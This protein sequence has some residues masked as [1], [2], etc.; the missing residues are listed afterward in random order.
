MVDFYSHFPELHLLKQ[1]RCEGVI[2]AL[3]SIF[4][5]HGVPASIMADNMP[6]NS[7]LMSQL[8]GEWRFQINTSSPHYPRSSGMAECYV[9]TIKHF[10]KKPDGEGDLYAALL[11]YRQTPIAGL[12]Y[13][14]SFCLADA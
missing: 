7:C 4:A 2:A 6:F 11:A 14:L 8:V 10:L 5:V 13:R 9:Q 1:K 12:L 3:K